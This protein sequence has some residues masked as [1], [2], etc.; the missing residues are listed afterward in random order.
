MPLTVKHDAFS[1]QLVAEQAA[2]LEELSQKQVETLD[3]QNWNVVEIFRTMRNSF[4]PPG[5]T[6][7][8]FA[9]SVVQPILRYFQK[10]AR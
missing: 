9:R 4:L 7:E 10:K 2:R 6:R 3:T 8:R 1:I 5:S